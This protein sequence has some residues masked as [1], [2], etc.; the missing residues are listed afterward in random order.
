[1]PWPAIAYEELP[2]LR[3]PDELALIP[4]SRRRAIAPTYRAAVPAAIADAMPEIP[5]QLRSRIDSL[6]VD[7][8]RAD[9]R[10][11]ARGYDLPA[12]LLRSESAASSQIEN[13][14]SS[15]RNV[16]LAELS[17]EGPHN[18]LLIAG[19][20]A[21]MRE[22]L[23]LPDEMSVQGI[24]NVHRALMGATGAS[25]AGRLRDEQVWV[26]GTAYSPHGA[27]YVAPQVARIAGCLEDVVA[28]SRREDVNPVVKAAIV[29]AQFE[30]IHPFIDGNGR[31][32]RALLHKVLQSDGM[33]TKVTLP[34]S[35]GLLDAVDS[36]MGSIVSYQAGDPI[37]V[38]EN[39][40]DALEMA[41]SLGSL[42]DRRFED[43]LGKW[44]ERI[45]E[46][47]GSAIH[48]LPAV[49]VEQPVVSVAYLAQRMEITPRAA[50]NMVERACGYGILR[51]IGNRRRGVF[52]QADELIDL[53][54]ELSSVQGIRR[55]LAS[56]RR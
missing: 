10:Q 1:M 53:L 19:N 15:V 18:A 41:C 31:T 23:S 5:Q 43:V 26:G 25:F 11:E 22:A 34:I 14:T 38:V 30:T 56:G 16:A 33:L 21:A 50:L 37:P 51:P 28:F 2:W 36:Y 6:V 42:A 13:L 54:E 12:L 4:K 44:E 45:S 32:G 49:L 40:V 7:L 20:I 3:D 8:A 9:A 48:R 46:R 35:A 55:V 47:A 52:Y 24:L 17:G 29:H 27:L 39:M